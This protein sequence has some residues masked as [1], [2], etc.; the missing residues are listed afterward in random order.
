LPKISKRLQRD[1]FLV[2][3]KNP[4]QLCWYFTSALEVEGI[5]T[6]V[7]D[8]SATQQEGVYKLPALNF[9][10]DVMT[11]ENENVININEY[12][13]GTMGERPLDDLNQIKRALNLL[14][15]PTTE[16]KNAKEPRSTASR[17]TSKT[18]AKK[19][20]SKTKEDVERSSIVKLFQNA[21]SRESLALEGRSADQSSLKK[22]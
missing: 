1:S 20:R 5:R 18:I 17:T 12:A 15:D 11:F 16:C 2:T 19:S 9:A 13:L 6:H 21:R 10:K 14:L 8:E 4:L 3:I 22:I 7:P